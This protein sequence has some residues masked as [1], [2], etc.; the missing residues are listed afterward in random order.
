MTCGRTAGMFLAMTPDLA[1]PIGRFQPATS[2]TAT[3]R[4]GAI[5]HLAELPHELRGALHGLSDAQL[6]TP[7]RP[8]GWTVRQV[9][10]HLADSHTSALHRI[11][12]AL[13]ED[14][15]T[16][17]PYNENAFAE[18][19]D[20]KLPVDS[21][22]AM[23]DGAHAHLVVILRALDAEQFARPMHHPERGALSIDFMVALYSWHGRHHLAHITGVRHRQGW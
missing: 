19:P 10:H 20:A 15:P 5:A 18:L 12:L 7:Y 22:L 9:V 23:I 14:N 21:S 11:K 3:D 1:Y 13:T 6:D 8:G 16:L 2:Y 17:K 4:E